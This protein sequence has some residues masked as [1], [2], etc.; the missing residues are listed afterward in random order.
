VSARRT[1]SRSHRAQRWARPTGCPDRRGALLAT[2]DLRPGLPSTSWRRRVSPDRNARKCARMAALWGLVRCMSPEIR[3]DPD[4]GAGHVTAS[5]AR[6]RAGEP[7]ARS[8][9]RTWRAAEALGYAS[10]GL[11]RPGHHAGR[12]VRDQARCVHGCVRLDGR[13]DRWMSRR[14]DSTPGSVAVWAVVSAPRVSRGRC[15]QRCCGAGQRRM[16]PSGGFRALSGQSV[17]GEP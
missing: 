15:L 3:E 9:G 16:S 11:S 10:S 2:A 1:G 5:A 13:G 12:R 14:T 6:A 7:A 8:M 17:C 4:A